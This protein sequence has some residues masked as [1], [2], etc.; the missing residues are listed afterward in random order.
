MRRMEVALVYCRE[1]TPMRYDNDDP[2]RPWKRRKNQG[3]SF[4]VHVCASGCV[5]KRVE[6]EC[7]MCAN[8]ET[9]PR[10]RLLRSTVGGN[11]RMK[12]RER[13]KQCEACTHTYICM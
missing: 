8:M 11:G 9:R 4:C 10:T 12:R 6:E 7:L 5:V 13:E 2:T 1:R 3:F